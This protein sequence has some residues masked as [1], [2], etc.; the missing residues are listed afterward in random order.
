[1]ARWRLFAMATLAQAD[2]VIAAWDAKYEQ[3]FWRPITGIR[4]AANDG[5]AITKTIGS[6]TFTANPGTR[7]G[8][9]QYMDFPLSL[10]PFPDNVDVLRMPAKW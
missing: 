5:N 4:G 2:A 10:G 3:D 9:G 7:I 6:V 8:P 1:M